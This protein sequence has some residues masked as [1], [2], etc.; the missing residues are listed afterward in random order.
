M[1]EKISLNGSWNLDFKHPQTGKHTTLIADVPIEAEVVLSNNGIIGDLMPPD[2]PADLSAV[3]NTRWHYSRTFVKPA[4]Q[5]DEEIYL[6]FDGI[7]PASEIFL[8]NKHILSTDNAM[9]S[10]Q[11]EVTDLLEDENCL[12]VV[13]STDKE[14]A[15]KYG[16]PLPGSG[17]G[18]AI[19]S[20][21]RKAR[22]VYGWD[23]APVLPLR[24]IS[25]DVA[26]EIKK[27]NR[28]EDAYI[29]TM[30]ANINMQQAEVG[31]YFSF[32]LDDDI[33]DN[34]VLQLEFFKDGK[35]IFKQNSSVINNVSRT[36][37]HGIYIDNPALW[38][39][40]GY[41]KAE[42]YTY[43]A[44]LCCGNEAIDTQE[45][46]FG[47]REIELVRT[48]TLDHDGNGKFHFLCNGVKIYIRGTNWKVLNA[49]HSKS[50][51]TM[52]QA[53][54]L[55]TRCNCNLIRVWG[56]GIYENENF[57][58]WCDQNGMLV[59]Q[60]FMFAC[61]FP[62]R[63]RKYEDN[64][65]HEAEFIVKSLR[66]HPSLALWCGDNESDNTLFWD[67]FI[68]LPIR[69][70]DNYLSRNILKEA[71][72]THDPWRNYMPSSPFIDDSIF[73]DN[74][75]RRDFDNY[76]KRV[77]EQHYYT[78]DADYEKAFDQTNAIFIS[79]CGPFFY[80]ALSETPSI[81][82]LEHRRI[83]DNWNKTI[84]NPELLYHQ[85]ANYIITWCESAKKHLD[86]RF[87]AD[88]N[89]TPDKKEEF[90]TAVN[91]SCAEDFKYCIEKFRSEK[92]RRAGLIWWSLC[93][94][95][96]MAF[97]YS[98]VDSEYKPKMPFYWIAASQEPQVIIGRKDNGKISLY[99]VN[100]TLEEFSGVCEI[101][102][103]DGT[104]N[105]CNQKQIS[106]TSA[107]NTSSKFAELDM[108][109]EQMLMLFKYGNVTNHLIAANAPF[110]F[111]KC[112]LWAEI[113]RGIYQY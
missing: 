89:I 80:N 42:L 69:P 13:V 31:Y 39:P 27:R 57:F 98:A 55:T 17:Y 82:E 81:Y 32:K 107:K 46:I 92:F 40:R 51:D 62:C 66:N 65:R 86:F 71:V 83:K 1:T 4:V 85:S 43:R 91:F 106:F 70:S 64:V 11:V 102:Y 2:T 35:S 77:P 50:G 111:E 36:I 3:E 8:N 90:I 76:L 38:F 9:I 15:K 21:L 104:G 79:E 87:G 44:V 54:E 97:N 94:M 88:S 112:K 74:A 5:S 16:V 52:R 18:N 33:A 58:N 109:A 72:I 75:S 84:V 113:L 59:W 99:A 19:N 101:S 108:P 95:W 20:F 26:L 103:I 47:I 48:N 61:E 45:G 49:I 96:K 105:I 100:D 34:A 29:Y 60:D 63:N 25:K 37:R 12:E 14:T 41:G 73:E 24:G 6:V 78:G 53:L 23:N 22:H 28:I 30:Q 7:D 67:N 56:G 110:D 68:P 10:H 93:D